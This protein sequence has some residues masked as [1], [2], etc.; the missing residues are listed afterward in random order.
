M[1]TLGVIADTHIPDRGKKLHPQALK[2]FREANVDAILHAGD[3]STRQVLRELEQIA[4]VHVVRGNVDMLIPTGL[5]DQVELTFEGVTIGMTHGHGGFYRYA[6]D[7][8]TMMIRG[9]HP[10]SYF[11]ENAM[12]KFPAV[13]V[14]I[15]GHSHVPICK[16]VGNQLIFNPGSPTVPN[17]N[18]PNPQQTVGLLHIDGENV[19]GEIVELER[20][21]L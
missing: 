5:P 14:I 12:R 11:E 13:D 20:M 10:F 16:Q 19:R 21:K 3:L 18:G 15:L 6:I 1:Q 2:T 4:P 9:P 17:R 8:V 7:R